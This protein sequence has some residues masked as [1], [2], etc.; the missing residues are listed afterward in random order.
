MSIVQ[1]VA[2]MTDYGVWSFADDVMELAPTTLTAAEAAVV[3]MCGDLPSGQAFRKDAR[4]VMENIVVHAHLHG[5]ID[6]NQE[7]EGE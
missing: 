3:A 2:G 6:I 7:P 1:Q 5:V 4:R